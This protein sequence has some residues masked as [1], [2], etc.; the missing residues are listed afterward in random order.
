MDEP[1]IDTPAVDVAPVDTTP[2]E[3]T[4]IE[5]THPGDTP[6]VDPNE[7]MWGDLKP[8]APVDPAAPPA[9]PEEFSKVLGIS[10]Y[11]KEPAHVESAVR[12]AS[13]V[14]DVVSGKSP[15]SGL[16]EAM[17]VQNPAQY[18]KSVTEDIIPYIE[19]ITGKKFGGEQT[20]P[21][22]LA[23]M[24]AEMERMKQAPLLEAQQREQQQY[25]QRAEQAGG[26]KLEE[27]IK[28]GNGI[29]DGD[30]QGAV[31]AVGAQINKMGLNPQ[32]VMKQVLSGNMA[33]LEKAYKAAEKAQTLQAKAYA[34]RMMARYKTLKGSVPTPKGGSSAAT[35]G[36]GKE[37]LTTQAGRSKAM[38]K[39]FAEGRDTL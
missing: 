24:R 12:T 36:D 39:A 17:R 14:W 23:E 28:G 34:D 19:K 11:V 20:A 31:Q 3:T 8:D 5:V 7:A 10:E 13:E 6:P 32:D 21:D 26:V 33:N 27:L 22:P 9:I 16:L 1:V 15:A 37:D 35:S 2:V 38:A 25:V 30:I 29:F 18:E 4:P